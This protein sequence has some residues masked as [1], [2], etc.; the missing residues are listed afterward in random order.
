M[1]GQHAF[2]P[3]SG[4]KA[5][6][7]CAMWPTMNATFPQAD[8]Q[9]TVLGTQAHEYVWGRLESDNSEFAEAAELMRDVMSVRL[10]GSHPP[11]IEQALRCSNIHSECWGT[12]DVTAYVPSARRLEIIDLKF[13]HRFV[14]EFQNGQGICYGSGH[15]ARFTPGAVETVAFTVVQPRCYSAVPVRTWEVGIERFRELEAEYH[16]AANRCM[17]PNPVATINSECRYCPGRHVCEVLQREAYNAADLSGYTTAVD[18]SGIAASRELRVLEDALSVLEARVNGLKEVVIAKIKAGEQV[19]FHQLAFGSGRLK[20]DKPAAEIA[21]LG[22]LF[23]INLNKHDIVTPA[24]AMK[25]GLDEGV[26]KAYC[27][28]TAGIESLTPVDLSTAAR[29][30][31]HE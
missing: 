28:T 10:Q 8:T 16:E 2:L 11:W 30:F 22:S 4:A 20:W 6:R 29:S 18:I 5:W 14:D 12:P 1:S 13:G 19:P 27:T 7:Q 26:V 25:K 17:L 23:G 21:A 9:D 31:S 3:P 24:Q 15:L